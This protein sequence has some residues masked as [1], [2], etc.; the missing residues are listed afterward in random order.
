MTVELLVSS[1][2]P[3]GIIW[4]LIIFW[5]R[6]NFDFGPIFRSISTIDNLVIYT[7]NY[8]NCS[9]GID[10][11]SR[12]CCIICNMTDMISWKYH[13]IVF[14]TLQ[15]FAGN[16]HWYLLSFSQILVKILHN[17][18]DQLICVLQSVSTISALYIE[19]YKLIM[20]KLNIK[21]E[22]NGSNISNPN[23]IILHANNIYI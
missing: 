3:L 21:W 7:L 16:F 19:E 22:V 10:M 8:C 18:Q 17:I 20:Q 15:W 23:S 14:F 5:H 11:S 1:D 2:F 6:N 13:D 12:A 4:L 9:V